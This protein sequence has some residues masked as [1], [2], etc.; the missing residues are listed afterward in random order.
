MVMWCPYCGDK[1]ENGEPEG[2]FFYTTENKFS[3]TCPKCKRK[4]T[5]RRC[6][7]CGYRWT[8]RNLAAL[9]NSCPKCCSPYW[10]REKTQNR[11]DSDTNIREIRKD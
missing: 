5:E 2:M 6:Y 1:D 4:L 10:N 7:R 3:N 11:D 9:P 8:A